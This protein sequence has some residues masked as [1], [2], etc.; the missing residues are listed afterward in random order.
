MKNLLTGILKYHLIPIVA[1][2]AFTLLVYYLFLWLKPEIENHI[3]RGQHTAF[4]GAFGNCAENEQAEL[5]LAGALDD[6][7]VI[8]MFGSS[9]LGS[10]AYSSYFFLPDSLN[11]PLVAFGHAHHQHF[12][13]FCE[14]LAMQKYLKKSKICIVISPGWF[15]TEGTNIEAFLEF[16]RPNF[17]KSIIHNKEIPLQYKIEIGRFVSEHFSDI[18]HPAEYLYYFRDLYEDRKKPV[19]NE[20]LQQTTK[21][22]KVQYEIKKGSFEK[23]EVAN[24]DWQQTAARLQ[25]KFLDSNQ[26]N[27]IYVSNA[28]YSE[29]LLKNG[30]FI[31]SKPVKIAKPSANR[32]YQDFLLMIEILKQNGCEASFIIQPLNP[33]YY[34]GLENY[35]EVIAGMK[36]VMEQNN[37]PYLDMFVTGKKAYQPAT[38]NDIMHLGDYGWNRINRFL[39]E[40]YAKQ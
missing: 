5:E 23:R 2:T 3:V 35:S 39:Y 10:M 6:P 28:Y 7:R 14:L 17:L 19:A 29:Y 25:K 8:T 12:S 24:V 37:F 13:I 11:M 1:A 20:V 32:E 22:N 15:E 40:N 34:E 18:D 36:K 21:V 27:A 31:K 33:Y 9:E 38:L 4:S 16:V 30:V 26:N